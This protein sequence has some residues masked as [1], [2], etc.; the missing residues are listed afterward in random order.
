MDEPID[1]I[2]GMPFT[3]L[4]PVSDEKPV[5]FKYNIYSSEL[6]LSVI[7]E[8]QRGFFRILAKLIPATEHQN[9]PTIAEKKK[10]DSQNDT[11]T[12]TKIF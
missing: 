11:K 2:D 1:L 5:Y 3:Y 4:G 12:S 10:Y 7:L 9:Y 8:N 6:P